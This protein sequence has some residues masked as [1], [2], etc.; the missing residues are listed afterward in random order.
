MR[1]VDDRMRALADQ[2][3]PG[4]HTTEEARGSSPASRNKGVWPASGTSA[5]EQRL[6]LLDPGRGGARL[7]LKLTR[8]LWAAAEHDRCSSSSTAA[9]AGE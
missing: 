5:G 9:A 4:C 2:L 6:T 7:G 8:I 1:L 3:P